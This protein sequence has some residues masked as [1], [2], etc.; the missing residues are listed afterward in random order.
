MLNPLIAL[1]LALSTPPAAAGSSPILHVDPARG[2][3]HT[4]GQALAAAQ[5]GNTILL[6]PGRYPED[7]A[8]ATPGITIRGPRTAVVTGAGTSTR[9]IQVH[10][11]DTTLDG[12]TIDGKVCDELI[13]ACYRDKAIYAVSL[14]AGD[15][16]SRTRILGMRLTNL[17]GE[18]VRL[19]YHATDSLVA[20]NEIGPCGVYDFQV[21]NSTT[22]Q[23]GEGVYIGT[24]PSQVHWNP[25][26]EPDPS[27]GN[28]V[29]YN[30][31]NTQGAECV[32][33]KEG[34]SYNDVAFN[35]CTG[36][37]PRNGNSG[38]MES[39]GSYNTF[40]HNKI[41]ANAAAGIRIG[42]AQPGDAVGNHIYENEI[43][44]NLRGGIKAQEPG[45]YGRI[46]GNVMSGNI[47]GNVVGT[48]KAQLPDPT[49]AC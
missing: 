10:A 41:Y 37:L 49:A 24:S 47:G 48:Y 42:G 20:F 29:Y 28:R 13:E 44:D 19:K 3:F 8:I 22:G 31:F 15:G 38:A 35:D 25:S 6:H 32:D 2:P 40:R 26:P 4:I 36:Q 18:C 12:F 16:V 14:V 7:L 43:F 46:C 30:V 1:M 34:A 17:G 45:E 5:A 9:I 23:N 39:R 33:I 27:N 21:P 11:D